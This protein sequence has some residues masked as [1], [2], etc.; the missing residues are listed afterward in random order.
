MRTRQPYNFFKIK[1]SYDLSQMPVLAILR[2]NNSV[3]GRSA[4]FGKSKFSRKISQ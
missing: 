2:E 3:E 1:L 4:E